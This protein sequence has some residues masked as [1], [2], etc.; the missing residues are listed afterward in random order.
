MFLVM[1]PAAGDGDVPLVSLTYDYDFDEACADRGDRRLDRDAVDELDRL[2]PRL[3]AAWSDDGPALLQGAR[4][5]VGRPFDFRKA[6]ARLLTCD[7]ASRSRPLVINVRPYLRAT[8]GRRRA[9]L[10]Q[11][12]STVV[13]EVLHRYVADLMA[14]QGLSET[15]LLRKYAAEPQEVLD[16]LQVFAIEEVAYAAAGRERD[17]EDMKSFESHL[18]KAKMFGRSRHIV[19]AEGAEAF[20]AELR[21]E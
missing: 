4:E 10:R 3:E 7:V 15:P 11:F 13:H 8:S 5:A 2:I 1:R 21:G 6:T 17:L 14:D 16:H 9:P 12:A 18:V 19:R 20:V